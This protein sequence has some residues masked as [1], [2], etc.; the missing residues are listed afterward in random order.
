[1]DFSKIKTFTIPQGVVTKISVNGII[2]WKKGDDI[3]TLATPTISLDGDTLIIT[4]IDRRAETIIVFV[5]GEVARTIEA[6]K[7]T[8]VEMQENASGGIT[9][10]IWS[11]D[12]TAENGIYIIGEENNASE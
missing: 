4:A 2:I 5:N 6:D 1:M 9:Y 3:Q 10:T 7:E 12:Y 8:T 11:N